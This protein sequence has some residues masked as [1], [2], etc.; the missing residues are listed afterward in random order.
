MSYVVIQHPKKTHYPKK[1]LKRS[2]LED[3]CD[4]SRAL[5]F[6]KVMLIDVQFASLLGKVTTPLNKAKQTNPLLLH[7]SARRACKFSGQLR[8][9][10]NRGVDPSHVEINNTEP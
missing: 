7:N 1:I 6:K 9:L 8:L 5:Q 4:L 10:L 3:C 2:V